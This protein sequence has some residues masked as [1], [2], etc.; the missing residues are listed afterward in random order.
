MVGCRKEERRRERRMRKMRESSARKNRKKAWRI[1]SKGK[2]TL[3]LFLSYFTFS[4]VPPVFPHI[5]FNSVRLSSFHCLYYVILEVM[6]WNPYETDVIVEPVFQ[7][8]TTVQYRKPWGPCEDGG[9]KT[10]SRTWETSVRVPWETIINLFTLT[11]A[12]CFSCTTSSLDDYRGLLPLVQYF[13][14][15]DCFLGPMGS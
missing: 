8:K 7:V 5:K 6:H 13:F 9:Q 2:Q 12:N 3:S 1:G 15:G 4:L 14:P 11:R 10:K